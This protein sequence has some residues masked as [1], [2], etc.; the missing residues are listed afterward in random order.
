MSSSVIFPGRRHSPVTVSEVCNEAW[1][2]RDKELKLQSIFSELVCTEASPLIATCNILIICLVLK[3]KKRE[4][5]D[6]PGH[7]SWVLWPEGSGVTFENQVVGIR[8]SGTSD[9][10]FFTTPLTKTFF[11]LYLTPY[12]YHLV[13]KCNATAFQLYNLRQLTWLLNNFSFSLIFKTRQ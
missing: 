10:R 4:I 7:S 8:G 2:K 5:V 13:F 11:Q 9:P 6:R 3:I 12:P 1:R